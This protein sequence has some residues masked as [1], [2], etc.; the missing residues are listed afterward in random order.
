MLQRQ[1][2]PAM[3]CCSDRATLRRHALQASL[4]A[5]VIADMVLA[6]Y[7][8]VAPSGTTDWSSGQTSLA[9]STMDLSCNGSH[10]PAGIPMLQLN[11]YTA[12]EGQ[13]TEQGLQQRHAS[14]AFNHHERPA[15]LHAA[16]QPAAS[17][18]GGRLMQRLRVFVLPMGAKGRA[19]LPG[20]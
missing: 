3:N 2:R 5:A 8:C 19:W 6:A 20:Q 13:L 9:S 18:V 17:G 10:G 11:S 4:C 7:P 15:L 12:H 1:V 14:G 16:K